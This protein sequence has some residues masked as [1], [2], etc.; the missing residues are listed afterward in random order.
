VTLTALAALPA[1]AA[2]AA[3]AQEKVKIGILST[4]SGPQAVAGHQQRNGFELAVKMLGGRLGGREAVVLVRDDEHEPDAAV[5]RAK[6]LV[7]R[8]KA[9][10]IVGPLRADILAAIVKPVTE[11]GAFLISPGAGPANFAGKDC[12]PNL[13]VTSYQTDQIFQVLGEY[14]QH[15]SL[16]TAL[17]LATD[18][19]LGRDAAA[20]IRRFYRG[21]IL[22]ELYVPGDQRDY[23]AELAKILASKPAAVFVVLPG[24]TGVDFVRQFHDAGFAGSV[25]ALTAFTIDEITLLQQRDAAVSF[26]A[27]ANWAPNLDNPQNRVFVAEYEKTYGTVPASVAFQAHDTALLLDSALKATG[28]DTSDKDA[29]RAALLKAEFSSLRGGF[30]FNTNHYPI[31]DFYLVK[32]AR[33]ADGKFQTEIVQKVFADYIDSYA[34]DCPMK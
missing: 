6:A 31:Q 16:R 12:S 26:F 2:T 4:L 18:D 28:G 23:T 15:T 14:A 3:G 32:A 30:K 24:R 33:R 17:L 1:I 9:D 19:R 8:D 13:F 10:V 20:G 5:A 29:L 34:R 7:E 25:K 11:S 22:A 21:K 27:G